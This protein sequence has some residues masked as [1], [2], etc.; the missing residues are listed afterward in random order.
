MQLNHCTRCGRSVA[1]YSPGTASISEFFE[2]GTEP[3]TTQLEC[4][5][6]G[7][8][9]S[10]CLGDTGRACHGCGEFMPLYCDF[11]GACGHELT[12]LTSKVPR[13]PNRGRGDAQGTVGI[14]DIIALGARLG[15]LRDAAASRGIEFDRLIGHGGYGV[16]FAA[17][18]PGLAPPQGATSDG[19]DAVVKLPLLWPRVYDSRASRHGPG[20][21]VQRGETGPFYI[22][23][24]HTEAQARALLEAACEAQKRRPCRVLPAFLGSVEIEGVFAA[25]FERLPGTSL[26]QEQPDGPSSLQSFCRNIAVAL[27]DMHAT[28][29]PH[30]DVKPAHIYCSGTDCNVRLLDPLVDAEWF[31]SI[32]YTLGPN[33]CSNDREKVGRTQDVA[34]LVPIL[35][36]IFGGDLGWGR[37]VLLSLCNR[38]NGRFGRG[39]D[40]ERLR[41]NLERELA[42]VPSPIREWALKVG[43]DYIG[44]YG[45][46][47]A[48]PAA[49]PLEE[50]W[51]GERLRELAA[52]AIEGADNVAPP[53]V[54]A[55]AP[56]TVVAIDQ[57]P[58]MIDAR[59]KDLYCTH[60]GCAATPSRQES[61]RNNEHRHAGPDAYRCD[62][63]G[64]SS[65]LL[66]LDETMYPGPCGHT[67]YARWKH[68]ARCGT[69]TSSR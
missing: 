31:G 64:E 53:K 55:V 22:D 19:V 33:M 11:C 61:T 13:E 66:I 24:V 62:R 2:Y 6:C 20:H 12:C 43:R 39:F 10:P 51:A 23:S 56:S 29:G 58:P 38:F 14:D 9:H 49:A 8:Q 63:C 16:V 7:V 27:L 57:A 65:M 40:V 3:D 15:A 68:C 41:A 46:T 1:P 25:F 30:G 54:D 69:R 45:D 42:D 36:E 52:I 32:G 50:D 59:S 37:D 47:N 60:C 67:V 18:G 26:A 21:I 35:A 4:E 44:F 48:P 17:R 28:F 34:A 5:R